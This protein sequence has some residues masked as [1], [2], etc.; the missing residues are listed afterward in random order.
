M[1]ISKSGKLEIIMGSLF[2]ITF[3]LSLFDKIRPTDFLLLLLGLLVIIPGIFN[4]TKNNQKKFYRLIMTVITV[5][6]LII[7]YK[8]SFY[9]ET[10]NLIS[11]GVFTLFSILFMYW[12]PREWK[13]RRELKKHDEVIE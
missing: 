13:T 6:M 1:I 4:F 12:V 11:L 2:I 5:S 7:F 10:L 3:I 8:Y 9:E